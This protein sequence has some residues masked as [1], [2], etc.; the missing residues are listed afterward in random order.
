MVETPCLRSN[1]TIEFFTSLIKSESEY[2]VRTLD[3]S[4]LSHARSVKVVL[5]QQNFRAANTLR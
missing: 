3:D 5:S 1:R 4:H 2:I